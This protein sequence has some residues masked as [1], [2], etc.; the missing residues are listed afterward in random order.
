MWCVSGKDDRQKHNKLS[1]ISSRRCFSC[2]SST[3]V[4]LLMPPL[5]LTVN[6]VGYEA[7]LPGPQE[8]HHGDGTG[9]QAAGRQLTP[10]AALNVRHDVLLPPDSRI[11][12]AH[13]RLSV[14]LQMIHTITLV[15]D[16][17]LGV[18]T[19]CRYQICPGLTSRA[20]CVG[21]PTIPYTS[22]CHPRQRATP[23]NAE[24]AAVERQ[25]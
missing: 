1:C 25:Q 22:S 14:L 17:V 7:V 24:P 16:G 10:G 9:R 19:V 13:T 12:T 4:V 3:P 15:H 2:P 11:C 6:R 8:C 21:V 5:P 23:S 18:G 20:K